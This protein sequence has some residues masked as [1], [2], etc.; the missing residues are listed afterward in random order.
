MA[1]IFIFI[2]LHWYISLFFQSFFYHRYAA[3]GLCS[4][5][6]GWEKFF[7]ICSYITHGTSFMK[8]GSYGIMHR[9]HHAL[10]DEEEDPHSPHYSAN[11][12]TLMLKTR[13]SYQ[14]VVQE[15]IEIEDKYRKDLPEWKWLEKIGHNWV[16]RLIWAMIYAG[17]FILLSTAWWHYLFLPIVLASSAF[18]GLVVNWW[19]HRFGYEN[20]QMTNTSKNIIPVDL[21][22][23]G[24]AYHNNHHKHPGRANNAVKWF[25]V[26]PTYQ[27][28]RL[29]HWLRIIRLQKVPVNT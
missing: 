26:D 15:K 10:T 8:T 13:N 11:A 27:V 3:H 18:Q 24:E 23:A 2:I 14:D 29:M 22:F 4:M 12:M 21:F 20:Y 19:A 16:S 7:Y 1:P 28:M 17:I 25:E 6:R 5:S 9:L